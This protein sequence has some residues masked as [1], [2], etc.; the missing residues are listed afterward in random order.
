MEWAD[1]GKTRLWAYMNR[2][3]EAPSKP[4][5]Y[6][7][8]SFGMGRARKAAEREMVPVETECTSHPKPHSQAPAGATTKKK[9]L[10]G[11]FVGADNKLKHKVKGILARQD[12]SRAVQLR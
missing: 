5:G 9:K 7:L 4:V 2:K 6:L 1:A 3:D 10:Q 12:G 11:S 8:W